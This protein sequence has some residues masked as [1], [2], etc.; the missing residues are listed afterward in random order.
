MQSLAPRD[1][2][3]IVL[4]HPP[5]DK[6]VIVSNFDLLVKVSCGVPEVTFCFDFEHKQL[7]ACNVCGAFGKVPVESPDG[8]GALVCVCV[9]E[10]DMTLWLEQRLAWT[11]E[12]FYYLHR[13]SGSR[14]HSRRTPCL[15][16]GRIWISSYVQSLHLKRSHHWYPCLRY[17]TMV[18]RSTPFDLKSFVI[19]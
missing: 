2:G 4:L 17:L 8:V 18:G 6:L 12:Y 1:V 11:A 10:L 3:G 5:A 13:L 16:R 7:F 9:C 19:F 14:L 15:V